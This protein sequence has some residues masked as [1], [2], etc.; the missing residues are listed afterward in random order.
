MPTEASPGRGARRRT[1]LLDAT[2]RVVARDGAA[3]ASHRAVA[4][5]AGVPLGS[6]T[7]YFASREEMLLEALRH[8]AEAD[9]ART[10]ERVTA[11]SGAG[12]D[13]DGWR[14]AILDW[15]QEEVAPGR[16]HVLVARHHL[17]L[18]ALRRPELRAVYGAWTAAGLELM[19]TVLAAAGSDAPAADAAVLVATI[20]GLA[21]NAVVL[22]GGAA[23]RARLVEDVVGRAVERLTAG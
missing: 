9:I 7:Y 10:R 18:E 4:A 14:R 21:L 17:R 20:D 2:L 3:G 8:A 5:E 23:G 15:A 19:E 13:R 6:T 22:G 16:A 11:L 12:L 1:A